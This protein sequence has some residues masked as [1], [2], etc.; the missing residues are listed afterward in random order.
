MPGQPAPQD[1]VARIRL[2]IAQRNRQP[3]RQPSDNRG[4]SQWGRPGRVVGAVSPGVVGPED[5]TGHVLAVEQEE[6]RSDLRQRYS[7]HCVPVGGRNDDGNSSGPG[8]VRA[9]RMICPGADK[10]EVRRLLS[11]VT[12]VPP[13]DAGKLSVQVAQL[14]THGGILR[15]PKFPMYE[16]PTI[17]FVRITG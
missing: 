12:L 7:G 1:W 8:V 11:T 16:I 10:P 5:D 17:V 15:H 14:L 9:C 3:S 2:R 6:G 4:T 13:R